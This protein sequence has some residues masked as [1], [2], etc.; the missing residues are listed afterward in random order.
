MKK[1]FTLSLKSI[2]ALVFFIG[3]LF[4]L[5]I[6]FYFVS[7]SYEELLQKKSKK[8][9]QQS[10][11]MAQ[12]IIDMTVEELNEAVKNTTFGSG[13]FA[14]VKNEDGRYIE[15]RLLQNMPSTA[16]FSAFVTERKAYSASYLLYDRAPLIREIRKIHT[17]ALEKRLTAIEIE[18]RKKLFFLSSK[19]VVDKS[20]NVIGIY[21]AAMEVNSANALINKIQK[22]TALDY[23]SIGFERYSIL[24]SGEE[25]LPKPVTVYDSLMTL[26][27]KMAYKTALEFNGIE[28]K[29]SIS[30]LQQSRMLRKQNKDF[31]AIFTTL[32]GVFILLIV[33]SVLAIQRIVAAPLKKL[34]RFAG[35]LLQSQRLHKPLQ[36]YI[37]EY[38]QLSDYLQNLFLQVKENEQQ[39]LLSK[40]E[41]EEEKNFQ[42]TLFESST[43]PTVVMDLKTFQ[44]ID[45]NPA[46]VS[47]YR[48]GSK[49]EL[50]GKTPLDVSAPRQYDQ[51]PSEK[52]ALDYINRA[53]KSGKIVFEWLHQTPDGELWDA[54]VHLLSFNT[55]GREMMQ[56]SI[57]DITQR[58]YAQ[59]QIQTLNT[60]LEQKVREQTRELRLQL[61]ELKHKDKMLQEQ[62]KLAAMGEMISAIAHQWRQPLNA[63]SINI[64]NLEDDYE[65]GLIDA[66]FLEEFVDKEIKMIN[67]MSR[68]IDDFRD[69]FKTD[70][71][72]TKFNIKDI[73]DN[74]HRL[75]HAQLQNHNIECTIEGEGFE[76][77]G[78]AS[79]MQQVFLNLFSNAKDAIVKNDTDGRITIRIDS[80]RGTVFFCDSGGGVQKE[81]LE[82]MFEPYFTTKD[83]DKGTGIGLHISRTIIVSHMSGDIQA[84]NT[85]NG[86]CIQI[87][88]GKK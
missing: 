75:L 61:E 55:E 19:A 32:V 48:F 35:E 57:V 54:E 49:E 15:N 79:Q 1:R 5:S 36:L 31:T 84:Y 71:T 39:L 40:K 28:S 42:K 23:V 25:F 76:I 80:Q 45:C 41:I 66:R 69:F 20:G 52:K 58:K 29:L 64:Q 59:Q 24:Q 4:M 51:T 38:Q 30:M 74:V 60:T 13:F 44:Y 26:D 43:I 50:I 7:N 67:F 27:D 65:E 87:D 72:K 6:A 86:L 70:K 56:F 53:I 68:T 81:V 62:S 34:Q 18:G 77:E 10:R 63:L 82:R 85:K 46:A 17:A 11:K 78:Y 88:L 8:Y 14:A 12:V 3:T 22:N 83:P 9:F 73:V 2:F 37:K 33:F 21:A 16:N 47:K